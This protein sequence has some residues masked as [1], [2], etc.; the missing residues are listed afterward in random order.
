[1]SNREPRRD[2]ETRDRERDQQ[3]NY[4]RRQGMQR[5]M[6]RDAADY[7]RERERLDREINGSQRSRDSQGRPRDPVFTDDAWRRGWGDY[8]DHQD[9]VERDKYRGDSWVNYKR[10]SERD[11]RRRRE[12]EV[13]Y[14]SSD[15]DKGQ[16]IGVSDH[17]LYNEELSFR[18][19]KR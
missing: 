4:M 5:D 16:G 9:R 6:D 2:R 17:E 13:G 18:T 19:Y 7:V 15:P 1:M 14:E 8:R 11:E 12:K 3:A 10:G